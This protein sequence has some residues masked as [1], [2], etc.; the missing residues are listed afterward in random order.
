[1]TSVNFTTQISDVKNLLD[2]IKHNLNNPEIGYSERRDALNYF[3][4]SPDGLASKRLIN[5]IEKNLE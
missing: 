2:V 5:A 4:F 1:M 3:H